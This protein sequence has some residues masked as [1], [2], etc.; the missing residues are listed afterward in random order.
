MNSQKTNS[1]KKY[2]KDRNIFISLS[3]MIRMMAI[4]I[5]SE[6]QLLAQLKEKQLLLELVNKY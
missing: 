5:V 6:M 2:Y 4:K 3:L 1:F